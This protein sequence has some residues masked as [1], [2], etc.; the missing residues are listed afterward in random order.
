M[1]SL[2]HRIETLT[3]E[4]NQLTTAL[5]EVVTA[6]A[7]P[8]L[9]AECGIGTIVATDLLITYGSN[10]KRLK[11]EASYAAICG[12]SAV[13]ASSGLQQR[14]RLNRGGDRQ[15]NSALYRAVIVRLQYHQATRDYMTKRLQEGKTKRETIRCL[16]RYLARHTYN[17]LT[18]QPT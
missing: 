17:T 10:T 11:T 15:A 16:K 9:L 7:P 14:H 6:T 13:D 5:K 18:Q 3:T 2:A 1:R 4:I 8:T 12:V